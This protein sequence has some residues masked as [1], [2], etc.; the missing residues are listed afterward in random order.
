MRT[1][2]LGESI[3]PFRVTEPLQAVIPWDVQRHELLDAHQAASRGYS[4]L[5]R[6]LEKVEALWEK[7]GK[8]N[9]SLREQYDFYGQL[10][11][12]FP[13]AAVRVVYTKAG[14]KPCGD[15]G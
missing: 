13:I 2:L 11:C 5:A 9:R 10:S 1:V 4:R 15:S 3:V 8:G 12:Q 7:K 6:W 14:T